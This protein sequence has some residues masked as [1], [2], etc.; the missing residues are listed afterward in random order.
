[1][2]GIGNQLFQFFAMYALA[3]RLRLTPIVCTRWFSDFHERTFL[4]AN[5]IDLDG[6]GCSIALQEKHRYAEVSR[7]AYWYL[8]RRIPA[9]G[10]FIE[11]EPYYDQRFEQ[12]SGINWLVG[13]FQSYRYFEPIRS[14]VVST[15]DHGLRRFCLSAGTMWEEKPPADVAIHI[16]LGDYLNA[17]N[18]LRYGG[19]S[20]TYLRGALED[21]RSQI[22]RSP[23]VAVFSDSPAEA[24]DLLR[25][26]FSDVEVSAPEQSIPFDGVRGAVDMLQ[27]TRYPRLI[28]ANSSFSWWAGFLAHS[29]GARIYYQTPWTF[30]PHNDG[31]DLAV[32]GWKA[33]PRL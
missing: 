6:L 3:K 2:G 18:R 8:H 21:V 19:F 30:R 7:T 33:I 16:R 9:P 25:A 23:R 32:P 1:M 12:V 5:V 28:L 26:T 10:K 29:R 13:Y 4:L 14:W 11:R 24:R 27:M 20:A 15:L 17:R 31:R 22:G